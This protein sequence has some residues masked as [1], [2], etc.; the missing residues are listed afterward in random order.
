ME[1]L[2]EERGSAVLDAEVLQVLLHELL[3]R[4]RSEGGAAWR[5]RHEGR[6]CRPLIQAASQL[7]LQ[8]R[9]RLGL[10]LQRSLVGHGWPAHT[11][12]L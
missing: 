8:L 12:S 2:C 3:L 10:R 7:H 9:Q 6:R 4:E 1:D 11:F 5:C